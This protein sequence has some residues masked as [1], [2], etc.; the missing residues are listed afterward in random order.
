MHESLKLCVIVCLSRYADIHAMGFIYSSRLVGRE[1][2]VFL[3]T[4][5]RMLLWKSTADGNS[6]ENA[7]SI[8]VTSVQRSG[9]QHLL[10]QMGTTQPN[11]KNRFLLLP[12]SQ[13][14]K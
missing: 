1:S 12:A 6:K 9:V 7:S 10:G 4:L 5:P 14:T 11:N 13:R 8:N 2:F 3:C